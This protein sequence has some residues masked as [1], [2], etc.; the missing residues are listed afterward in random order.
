MNDEE[1]ID[2]IRSLR[3]SAKQARAIDRSAILHK[4]ADT[5]EYLRAKCDMLNMLLDKK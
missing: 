5:L 1:I 3:D 4:A 2:L